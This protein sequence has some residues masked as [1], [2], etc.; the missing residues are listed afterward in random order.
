M[1]KKIA[2]LAALMM[3]AMLTLT[4][5]QSALVTSNVNLNK[6]GSGV[7][8]ISIVIYADE[9][10]LAGEESIEEPGTVGNN[11]KYLLVSGEELVAK[12]RS[13]AA[14]DMDV[15][16]TTAE[17][18]KTTVTLSY[19]FDS[20]EDYTAKTKTLAKDNASK[21]EA[22]TF[23]KNE[24]GTF[25]YKENTENTQ[26]SIDNIFFSLY[27]DPT[28]FSKDGQGDCDL[29][30]WGYNYDCIYTIISVSATIG[31][32][33]NTVNVNEYNNA[34]TKVELNWADYIEVTGTLAAD[35]PAGLPTG[36]IIG[37]CAG[38][39]VV[40]AAVIILIAKKSKKKAE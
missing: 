35:K 3:L 24:D 25:T 33:T 20:I 27:N 39:A 34:N 8:I 18:G 9:N 29:E 1:K 12:I 2:L 10:I 23:T 4:A 11:S 31:D 6:D 30:A 36:A 13:Y 19:A 7:K 32:A 28:A 17:D 21:I 37:I 38:A 5:C 40:I 26:N 14:L 15:T 16:A 22:P